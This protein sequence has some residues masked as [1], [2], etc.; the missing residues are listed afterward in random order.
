MTSNQLAASG[1]KANV[2]T[3]NARKAAMFE[4]GLR[5]PIRSMFQGAWDDIAK[6]LQSRDISLDV[7]SAVEHSLTVTFP[8]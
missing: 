1:K 7:N 6:A 8:L 3:E 5:D 2:N 4:S